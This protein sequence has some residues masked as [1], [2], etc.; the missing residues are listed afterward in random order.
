MMLFNS[1]CFIKSLFSF[2]IGC[3]NDKI[4]LSYGA[5]IL[6]LVILLDIIFKDGI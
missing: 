1:D 4:S 5:N 3:I 6:K 2:K